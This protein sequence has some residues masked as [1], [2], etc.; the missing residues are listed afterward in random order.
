MKAQGRE[1]IDIGPDFAERLR[2]RKNPAVGRSPSR[3]YGRERK[4][5]LD[6]DDYRREYIRTGKYQGGVPNLDLLPGVG[7]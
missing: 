1:I 6:Y 3:H 4:Q 5:L 2:H 7:P